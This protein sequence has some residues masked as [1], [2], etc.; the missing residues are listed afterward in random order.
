MRNTLLLGLA[1]TV[2]ALSSV[3]CGDASSTS[4]T[5]T[6]GGGYVPSVGEATEHDPNDVDTGGTDTGNP[7]ASATPSKPADAA[8]QAEQFGLTLS[9][10]TPV[11]DLGADVSVD[12]S[13]AQKN[14]FTGAVQLA[15]AGLPTGV[16]AVFTPATLTVGAAPATAKLVLTSAVSTVPSAANTSTPLQITATAG[17]V[18]ATANANFK[19]NPKVT[20]TIPMNIDA[21]RAANVGTQ[22][23]NQWGT[24]FGA[25]PTP[26]KTQEGN[27]IVVVVRNADSTAHIVHSGGAFAHGDTARPIQ[28]NDF[29]KLADGTVRTRTLSPTGASPINVAGYPHEGANG[30]SVSFRVQVQ[31]AP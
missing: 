4:G 21:L 28:P 8:G 27:G 20:L 15:A 3:A 26:L 11:V 31:V 5:R 22:F 12:V 24:A 19:V 16:T 25:T 18:K 17:A 23:L 9:T 1:A 10:T 29:E 13:V 6:R 2:L 30:P 7:N 14:G